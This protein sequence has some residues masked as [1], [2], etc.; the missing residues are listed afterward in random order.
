MAVKV[1]YRV[2]NGDT[3]A[4][5][6]MT[7]FHV[8]ANILCGSGEV[9]K[10][11]ITLEINVSV[12]SSNKMI[13]VCSGPQCSSFFPNRVPVAAAPPFAQIHN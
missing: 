8:C 7:R 9:G 3:V 10:R 1:V 12:P 11:D 5:M 4:C 6:E 13:C 2:G